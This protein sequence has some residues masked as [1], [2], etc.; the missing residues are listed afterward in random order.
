[1][2]VF[3]RD[4]AR[5]AE[6]YAIGVCGA[7]TV[8]VLCCAVNRRLDI[9]SRQRT[10][11]TALGVFLAVVALTIAGTK[12]NATAFA[13]G[14]VGLALV[15]RQGM[16]WQR[17]RLPEAVPEPAHG[18]LAELERGPIDLD[19]SRPRVM[20]AARG[21]YQAE[22]AVDLARRRGATLFTIFVRTLRVM[23]VTP[24]AVPRVENDPDAL[25]SLGTV[26]V[27]ARQYR[28]P[29]VPIYVTS[30]DIVDEIL[31]YTVTYGCDTLIL[32]KS[33]RRWFSRRIEGDVV[34]RVAQSL[35][36]EVALITRDADPHPMPPPPPPLGAP[37][38]APPVPAA[39]DGAADVPA[40]PT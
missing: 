15:T 30:P 37:V 18:W 16:A 11:M 29:F 4:V 36:N 38:S 32:G 8:N 5:L 9:S 24:G 22:F 21:R 27:L 35:P 17:S 10:A 6:L 12:W 13:G 34:T 19:P 28:V 40:G 2:L 31:D 1:V 25:E 20:L 39:D 14:L 23:D 3:E 26:A 33:R 7:I